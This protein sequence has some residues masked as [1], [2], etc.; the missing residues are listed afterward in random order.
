MMHEAS[1]EQRRVSPDFFPLVSHVQTTN[2]TVYAS[3]VCGI[4]FRRGRF[5]F[6]AIQDRRETYLL[7][8]QR[9]DHRPSSRR[10]IR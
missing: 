2:H 6:I 10:G 5:D 7:G 9:H 4:S 8:F 1:E 3:R